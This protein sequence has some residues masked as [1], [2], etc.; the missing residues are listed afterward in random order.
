M[1]LERNALEV[2]IILKNWLTGVL[3]IIF[4]SMY[5]ILS[6]IKLKLPLK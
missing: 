6:E 5:L 4:Q 2:N 1:Y 3:F